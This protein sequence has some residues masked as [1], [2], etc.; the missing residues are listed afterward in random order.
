M[1][2]TV[3]VDDVET[4]E[5]NGETRTRKF[6]RRVFPDM[7]PDELVLARRRIVNEAP[8]VKANIYL[9]DRVMGKPSDGDQTKIDDAVGAAYDA[10][11]DAL[12]QILTPDDFKKAQEALD[13]LGAKDGAQR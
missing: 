13:N 6:K 2:G 5:A 4:Y 9:A 8:D 7:E 1:A 10:I 12:Q 3:V 11:T